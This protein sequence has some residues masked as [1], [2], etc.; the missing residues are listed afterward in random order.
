M[1]NSSRMPAVYAGV[2]ATVLML[3]TSARADNCLLAPGRVTA[4]G[5]HWV[6]QTDP[7][8]NRRCW[9]LIA[10]DPAAQAGGASDPPHPPPPAPPPQRARTPRGPPPRRP[11]PAHRKQ[12]PISPQS[13]IARRPP[14][15]RMASRNLT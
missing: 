6:Y 14:R 5:V 1:P 8:T 3:D 11:R 7:A 2:L 10:T 12:W 15:M 13:R 4:P 9:Y